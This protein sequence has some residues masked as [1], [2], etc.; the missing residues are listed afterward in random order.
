[1]MQRW[2]LTARLLWLGLLPGL[3][4]MLALGALL[5]NS[6]EKSL[7]SGLA[8]QLS[9][10]ADSIQANFNVN[11]QGQ[12]QHTPSPSDAFG[13]IFSG[14]YWT[15]QT[16][17]EQLYSRSLWDDSLAPPQSTAHPDLLASSDPRE[18]PLLGIERKFTLNGQTAQLQVY[19]LAEEVNSD[20][21]RIRQALWTGLV[22][23]ALAATVTT[24]IQV[25]V[26]LRPLAQLR[27]RVAQLRT[28]DAPP[29]TPSTAS[30]ALQTDSSPLG[31]GFGPDLDPLAQEINELLERNA[32]MLARGRTHAADLSHALKTPLARLSAEASRAAHIPSSLVLEQV[33]SVNGL[34][35]RHLARTTHAGDAAPTLYQRIPVVEVL[36][37]LTQ[38]MRHVRPEKNLHWHV[39]CP[40]D[41]HWRGDRSDLEEMLGN[42]LDNASKWAASQVRIHAS[43]ESAGPMAGHSNAGQATG[44]AYAALR[45]TIADDGPGISANHLQNAMQRGQR[46]DESTPGTG[47][48]LSI[49]ADIAHSWG[50]KLSLRPSDSLGGLEATLQLR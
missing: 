40:P 48:G 1:M 21:A 47:L 22:A 26:G 19:T 35:E 7:Y 5:Y 41:L 9:E 38:L 6:I 12:W 24:L 28:S 49:V 32:R 43:R 27:Q 13:K 15:L 33:Q 11:A 23:F 50:G 2:G 25:R 31:Q 37:Q 10:R 36:T 29:P 16:P 46:F 34:I 20:L 42:L 44:T 17:N 18:R 14:W 30:T 3:A 45:I 4:A 39:H 8:Q